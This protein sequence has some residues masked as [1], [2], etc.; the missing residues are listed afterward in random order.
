MT[1][2]WRLWL[3]L[4]VVVV[5][6]AG[7]AWHWQS[8][9]I[10]IGGRWY[11]LSISG[12]LAKQRE[13]VARMQR[14]LLLQ[15]VADAYVPEL[16]DLLAAMTTRV[17]SGQIDLPW[18]A[19]VYTSYQRDLLL[20]RPGGV[21]RRSFDE[22][23]TAVNQYVEFYRLEKRPDASGVRL[24]DLAGEG[25]GRSFTVEEIEQAHRDGR[26]LTQE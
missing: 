15:P 21:P 26:D 7:A 9:L 11:L 5:A 8:Q 24:R 4:G 12:D 22:V 19:Y 18:A 10:G 2:R 14:T 6:L 13:A 20:Q 23:E 17:S 1:R 3:G 25:E 16:S